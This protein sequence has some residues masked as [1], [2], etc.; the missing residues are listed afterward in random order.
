MNNPGELSITL[1]GDH[2]AI[3]YLLDVER[4]A[5]RSLHDLLERTLHVVVETQNYRL[6]YT[7]TETELT[8]N[9]QVRD[10]EVHLTDTVT[11]YAT[12]LWE[13]LNHIP[14]WANPGA[15][16]AVQLRYSDVQAGDSLRVIKSFLVRNLAR[17]FGSGV[18]GPGPGGSPRPPWAGGSGG[19]RPRPTPGG[20]GGPGGV[21]G[22][23]RAWE[24][25]RNPWSMPS[26][27]GWPIMVHPINASEATE[28]TVLDS[29]FNM[30]G[31]VFKPTLNA[32]GLQL[33]ATLWLPGDKQPFPTHVNLDKPTII[34][35]VVPRSFS[36]AA[37]GTALDLV[38]GVKAKISSD[39]VTNAV[40]LDDNAFTGRNPHAWCVWDASHMRGVE[41]RL[42]VKKA[43]DSTVIVGGRSP[44][45]VNHL[46][47]AGSNALWSGIGAAIGALF[48]PLAGLAAAAGSFLGNVQG[49]LLKDKL[50]AWNMYQARSR[51]AHLGPYRYRAIVKP[52][53]AWSLSSLQAGFAA[54]QETKGS[55]ST[56]FTANDG[57][58]YVFGRDFV[59][60][61]QAAVRTHGILFGTYV[62]SVEVEVTRTGDVVKL[63]LGD[64]RLR[65]S[66]ER[67]FDNSLKT[68]A[69][70]I[71]RV[72][73]VVL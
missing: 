57:S 54:L 6:A 36:T 12:G 48:P 34:L 25:P 33:T 32:A 20:P 5:D 11:I 73:T 40:V 10:G 24:I 30:A 45:I 26:Q 61:D 15:G 41:T 4:I 37:T 70:V 56:E 44:Q 42:V 38:R 43:T 35:D 16:L 22:P 21:Q 52:G 13:H 1:P 7:V 23:G 47:A 9:K 68:I 8:T 51:Q 3:P 62:D 59:V 46:V 17:E 2:P 39:T 28:W 31:D 63:G 65:E 27:A 18:A 66:P 67:A 14:L 29:R 71:D 60:G 53:E 19:F 50:F 69:G 55:I 49:N 72:K 64:P 58:P